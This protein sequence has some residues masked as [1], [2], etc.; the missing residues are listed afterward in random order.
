M[1]S[2]TP[3]DGAT[4]TESVRFEPGVYFVPRGISIGRPGI[5]VEGEGVTLVGANKEGV[6]VSLSGVDGVEVRGI[7]L[8]DFYHGLRAENCSGLVISDCRITSTSEIA[9]NSVFLDIWLDASS[10]YGGAICLVSCADSEVV[11]ND[12][13]HQMNGLLTYGC[14]NLAV[15]RNQSNYNSGFG[16]HLYQTVDSVFEANSCDYCCRFEPR[17]GGLHFGHMGA[18]AT[19]FLAVMNSSRNLFLRNTARLGG[20]GFFLAGLSPNGTPCGCNE[21][22]FEENDA[23]LS[24]NIAFESTFCE[25]NVF[26]GNVADRCNFG[27]W[28]GYSKDFVIE[29]NRILWNRQAGIAVENGVGFRVSG[30]HFQSNGHGILLWS[31]YVEEFLKAYP[32]RDTSREW[33]I[34][35]NRFLNNGIGVRI[36]ADQDHGIRDQEVRGPDESRPH[37]HRIIKNDIQDNR[38]GVEFVR[39]S[40]NVLRENRIRNNVEAGVRLDDSSDNEIVNNLGLRGAYL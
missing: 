12:L 35:D 11:E 27:F 34:E 33:E 26:R 30:N 10:S 40:R 31:H 7:Q 18:D 14:K 15:R 37:S 2:V 3:I 21:N 17:E 23:S 1:K 36:A 22:V 6:G 24:P 16:I 9:P 19:G 25:R 38:V 29:N 5:R 32:D 8:R 4:L 20:D 28:C 39:T 13:Q